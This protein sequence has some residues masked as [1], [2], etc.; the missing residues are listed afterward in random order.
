MK[1]EHFTYLSNDHVTF[2]HAVRWIPDGKIRGILQI[3]H[4]M[5]EFVERYEEF[6]SYLAEKGILVTGN[7]HL[8]HGE[9]VRSEQD[10]GYFAE[11][12][13]NMVLIKD[14]HRLRKMT[15]EQYPGIPYFL[16]GHSMGSFLARQYLCGYG[17]GLTGAVIMGTGY[18]SRP[19]IMA[20]LTLT[21]TLAK[22][23][24]WRHRSRLID[25]LAFGGYNR[26][27]KNPRTDKDWLTKEEKIVDA[28]IADKRCQ[29]RFTLNAYYNMFLGLYKLTLP[30]YLA[31]MPKGLPVLFVAGAVDPVGN[32]G[33]GVIRVYTD[34]K[35][36]GMRNVE[37]RLYPGDRHEILNETDREKVYGDIAEWLERY[38]KKEAACE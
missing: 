20:A 23:K 28:Y 10:F 25:E 1:R 15:E 13:G 30:D 36:A 17:R 27:Q 7:D 6:A 35:K 19:E 32:N 38:M 4:G 31:N 5:V 8:G 2:I 21:K 37:L 33:K 3:S 22:T 14:I 16:L 12:N 26:S 11:E 24:G 34:F 9:S 18:H 29:F